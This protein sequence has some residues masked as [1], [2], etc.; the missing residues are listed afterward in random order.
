MSEARPALVGSGRLLG[1]RRLWVSLLALAVVMVVGTIGYVAFGFSLLDAIFQ[2]VTTIF[3]VGFGEVHPF[4]P[5]EKAFTIVLLL[6]GV[7]TA[8]YAAGVLIE[9]FVEGYLG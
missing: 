4:G 6:M 2:T 1:L 5:G 8:A 9:S 3:T 7:A